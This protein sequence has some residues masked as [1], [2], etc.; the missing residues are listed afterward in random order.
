MTR[1][2]LKLAVAELMYRAANKIYNPD[3][4]SEEITIGEIADIIIDKIFDEMPKPIYEFNAKPVMP[5]FGNEASFIIE[6]IDSADDYLEAQVPT[7]KKGKKYIIKI[8][9]VEDEK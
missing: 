8:Y 6:G 7:F 4:L 9:E 1:E 2:E 5:L 3:V